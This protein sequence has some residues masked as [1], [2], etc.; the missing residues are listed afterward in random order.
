[1]RIESEKQEQKYFR[2]YI[3]LAN[4]CETAIRIEAGKE[5]IYKLYGKISKWVNESGNG[6]SEIVK[7]SGISGKGEVYCVGEMENI[8][9]LDSFNTK[10][11]ASIEIYTITKWTPCLRMWVSICEKYLSE[12]YQL[13]FKAFEP[14][15]RICCTNDTETAETMFVIDAF[16]IGT[17]FDKYETE[18]TEDFLVGYLQKLLCTDEKSFI[19]L[20][21]L[22]DDSDFSDRVIITPWEYSDLSYWD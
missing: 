9:L 14:G 11:S 17:Q 1:M 6:L 4:L 12:D 16:N 15:C 22:L 3:D 13:F 5:N 7:Q 21:K 18:V 10:E 19:R 2:R 8:S 20:L